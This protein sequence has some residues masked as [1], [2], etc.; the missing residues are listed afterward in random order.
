MGNLLGRKKE[1]YSVDSPEEQKNNPLL[2]KFSPQI[3]RRLEWE[4]TKRFCQK[5][6]IKQA[7]LIN[8]FQHFLTHDEV[9]IRKFK[10]RVIDPKA[11]FA[12]FSS[13]VKVSLLNL[14]KLG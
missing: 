9:Y 6:K 7:H 8:V 10:V 11:K 2:P 12:P 5:Y 13:L 14:F 1:I 3:F 4:V